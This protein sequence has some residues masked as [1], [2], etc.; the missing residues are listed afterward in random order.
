[1]R[2]RKT[3]TKKGAIVSDIPGTSGRC[4]QMPRISS[5]IGTP[6]FEAS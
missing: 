5:S 4:E 1:M 6:A 2:L 3:L